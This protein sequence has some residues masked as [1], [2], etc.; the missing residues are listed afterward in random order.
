MMQRENAHCKICTRG[1]KN[2]V[3]DAY[4]PI[5]GQGMGMV[6][7]VSERARGGKTNKKLEKA[8]NNGKKQHAETTCRDSMQKTTILRSLHVVTSTTNGRL[9]DEYVDAG[10]SFR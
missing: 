8:K 9:L 6:R 5:Q 10:I 4:T 7:R 2:F 1:V 3:G